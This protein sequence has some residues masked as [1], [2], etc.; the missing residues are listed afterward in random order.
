MILVVLDFL[1]E[2]SRKAPLDLCGEEH[3]DLDVVTVAESGYFAKSLV[4]V[5]EDGLDETRC[6]LREGTRGR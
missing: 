6:K 3:V 4:F 2:H 5:G 1:L